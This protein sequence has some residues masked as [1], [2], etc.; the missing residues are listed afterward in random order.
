MRKFTPQEIKTFL[1]SLDRRLTEP[2]YFEVIGS[3]AAMLAFGLDRS[4]RDFDT[5]A[6]VEA[7]AE[8]WDETVLETGLDIPLD[9]VSVHQPP[10][11]YESRLREVKIPELVNIRIAVPEKHDWALMKIARFA[12]KDVDHILDVAT[13]LGFSSDIFL[14]RF[15]NEM[16]M[17]HGYKGNLIHYFLMTMLELFGEKVMREME[18]AIRSDKRWEY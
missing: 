12:D 7:I 14:D 2:V 1:L 13:R 18:V 5:V 10:Y 16:W 3:A 6:S 15:L 9:K 11:E 8:A 4:T 17:S